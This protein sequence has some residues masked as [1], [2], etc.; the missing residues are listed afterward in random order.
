MVLR[1]ETG[2]AV[3]TVMRELQRVPQRL[4]KGNMRDGGRRAEVLM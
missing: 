3:D 1:V 2:K 4:R